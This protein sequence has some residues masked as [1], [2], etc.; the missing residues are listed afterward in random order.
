MSHSICWNLPENFSTLAR[1]FYPFGNESRLVLRIG[2]KKKKKG[3][4]AMACL[5]LLELFGPRESER[6]HCY[7]LFC[8]YYTH[9]M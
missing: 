4:I 9:M 6:Y 3:S 8:E 1:Y 5:L 7:Y 2:V